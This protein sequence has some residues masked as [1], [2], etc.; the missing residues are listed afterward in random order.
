MDKDLRQLIDLGESGTV[1][2]KESF[3]KAAI[4]TMTAFANGEGG[5]LCD[6]D[7]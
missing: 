4:E 5:F 3:G 7:R 2:F 1:E 6:R